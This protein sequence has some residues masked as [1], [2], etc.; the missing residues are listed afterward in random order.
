MNILHERLNAVDIVKLAHRLT[1][2]DITAARYL[3]NDIIRNGNA[4]LLLDI[5]DLGFI[6]S[7]GLGLLVGSREEARKHKGDLFLLAPKPEVRALL[8]LTR[9]DQVFR[10][11]NNQTEAVIALH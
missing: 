7:R 11:F 3:I 9:L 8:E 4:K 10:I 5:S 6:D 2:A 1:A